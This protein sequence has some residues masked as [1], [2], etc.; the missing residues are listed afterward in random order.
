MDRLGDSA[1][2]RLFAVS[3]QFSQRDLHATSRSSH[4]RR[5]LFCCFILCLL[6]LLSLVLRRPGGGRD[7]RGRFVFLASASVLK[8]ERKQPNPNE[9]WGRGGQGPHLHSF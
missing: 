5:S 2:L 3:R 1:A 4:S 6:A 9:G 7:G 8:K